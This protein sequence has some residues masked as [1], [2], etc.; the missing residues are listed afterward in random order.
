MWGQ[1]LAH[2]GATE[3]RTIDTLTSERTFQLWSRVSNPTKTSDAAKL[4]LRRFNLGAGKAHGKKRCQ[5]SCLD[6]QD[7]VRT[8]AHSHVLK[9]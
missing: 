1:L 8:N 4:I 5:F 2:A 9:L 6:L 3:S 7:V